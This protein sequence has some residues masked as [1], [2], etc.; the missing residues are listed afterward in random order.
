MGDFQKFLQMGSKATE[1][2]I[3][4]ILSLP[5]K[6]FTDHD[7]RLPVKQIIYTAIITSPIW[8]PLVGISTILDKLSKKNQG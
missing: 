6:I 5:T 7:D 3:F 2:A 1:S 4:G 8:I